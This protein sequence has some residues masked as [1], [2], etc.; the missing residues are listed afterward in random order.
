MHKSDLSYA[1]LFDFIEYQHAN[2]PQE[3]SLVSWREGEWVS[4]S[5]QDILDLA[6]R[7]SAGLLDLGVIPGDKVAILSTTNRSEWNIVDL[8]VLQLGAVDVP[9]YPTITEKEIEYILCHSESKIVFLSDAALLEKVRSIQGNCPAL[10]AIYTFDKVDGAKHWTEVLA[11]DLD[12]AYELVQP[13]KE[14]VRYED[15]ATL[16][17]TSG[18]TGLPKGVMLSHRNL[19]SNVLASSPRLPVEPGSRSLSFLPLC[20][21]FERMLIY[22]YTYKGISVHYARSLDT[23]GD[24]MKS[25]KPHIFTAVP[26]LIEK[27][28]D[29]II[30]KGEALTGIKRKLFFW[31]VDLAEDFDYYGK[32]GAWYEFKLKIARK[33]IFSK[34]QEGL[35]GHVKL[36]ASGSAALSPRLN[37]IFN[38]AG[39]PIMEGYGLTETSPVISVNEIDHDGFRF[40]TTGRPIEHVEVKIAEDG[41]ILCKGPNLMM[42]YYKNPELTAEVIDKEGYFHTGDIGELVEGEFVKI[43]DRKKEIFKTSGG[44]YIAPQVMEN[45][46]KSSRFIEQI[47]VVGEGKKHPSALIVPNAE[48]LTEFCR[49]KG[50][51]QA[52]LEI[53]LQDPTV[54]Q[55][56]ESEVGRLNEDFNQ[57]ERIKKYRLIAEPWSV[58]GGEL[59]PTLK[60]RRKKVMEKYGHLVEAMYQEG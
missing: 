43:T 16:I 55:V 17:Y 36:A 34:W 3:S 28:Y 9:I 54:I 44:K 4:Y 10:Q 29:K 33:L 2:F 30:A 8:G 13:Y 32:N 6:H 42:G 37:R 14:D 25:V 56:F 47:M 35:G 24:D 31:A 60:L 1:R 7:M 50:I 5:S 52:S 20:H 45:K 49:S 27:M 39:I 22:L 46:F 48:T 26:R 40:G 57:Y 12:R 11:S 58:D 53:I 41:E 38:A 51:A 23:I 19:V 15:L 21:V 18:T 59:T